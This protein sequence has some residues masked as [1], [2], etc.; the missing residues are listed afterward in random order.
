MVLKVNVEIKP[1]KIV[2]LKSRGSEKRYVSRSQNC[3]G[4]NN[5]TYFP[6]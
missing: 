1:V 3:W 2:T 4:R 6:G 5:S